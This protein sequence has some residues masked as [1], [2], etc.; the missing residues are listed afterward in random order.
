MKSDHGKPELIM[1]SKYQHYPVTLLYS[2]GCKVIDTLVG[3]P[4]HISE[5]ESSFNLVSVHMD[6]GKL[7]WILLCDGVHNIKTEIESVGIL[8]ADFL[9]SAFFIFHTFREFRSNIF[10]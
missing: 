9:K 2:K 3:S 1:A 7:I 10:P 4:L 5:G 8:K 6:H